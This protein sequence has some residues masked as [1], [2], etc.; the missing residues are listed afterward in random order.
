MASRG[1]EFRFKPLTTRPATR[2][3]QSPAALFS[4]LT[5]SGRVSDLPT[6]SEVS[7]TRLHSQHAAPD[8]TCYLT[9]STSLSKDGHTPPE[10]QAI[11]FST[12]RVFVPSSQL[13][14]RMSA[15]VF[16]PSGMG[17]HVLGLLIPD[18]SEHHIPFVLMCNQP[19]NS[20]F[21]SQ[22]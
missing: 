8:I 17:R 2:S 18:V 7:A 3:V 4:T 22:V 13:Q 16:R 12:R 9:V 6:H 1:R 10:D 19:K 20:R 5:S 14:R 11:A 15:C 21:R